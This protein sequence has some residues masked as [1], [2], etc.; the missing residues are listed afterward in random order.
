MDFMKEMESLGTNVKEGMDR[1]MG[2]ASLYEMMLGMFVDSVKGDPISPDDFDSED[3]STLIQRV[4]TV[5]GTTGNLSITPLFIG[6]TRSLELL[7]S[8]Q[9]AQAKAEFEKILPLQ[10][11]IVACIEQHRN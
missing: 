1:V 3:L 2:D 9:A 7:R 11:K 6:Y 10:E 8:N 4:H 5:K